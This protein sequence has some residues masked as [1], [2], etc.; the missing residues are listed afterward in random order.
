MARCRIGLAVLLGA[1]AGC[2]GEEPPLILP[3]AGLDAS[4]PATDSGAASDAGAPNDAGF[5]P[6]ADAATAAEDA[7]AAPHD[8]SQPGGPDTGAAGDDAAQPVSPDA[9]QPAG[10]DAALPAGPDAAAPAGLDAASPAGQD[11]AQAPGEDAA[12]PAGDDAGQPAGPDADTCAPQAFLAQQ[13]QLDIYLMLDTSASMTTSIGGTDTRWTAIKSALDSFLSAPSTGLS[14]GLQYFPIMDT[15]GC[16]STATSCS[17]DGECGSCGPCAASQ[18]AGTNTVFGGSCMSGDYASPAVEI[19]SL[20]GARSAIV[21]SMA[22][23]SPEGGTPTS[24][25]LVGLLDHAK[26]WASLFPDHAVIALLATDGEPTECITSQPYLMSVASAA[27]SGTP[28]IPT[29]VIG[30]GTSLPAVNSIAV[31]GGTGSAYMVS[32]GTGLAAEFLTVLDTVRGKSA[33]CK[34][35]IPSGASSDFG[36]VNVRFTPS[37]GPAV[38]FPNVGLCTAGVDGWFYDNASAPK[39]IV[40]CDYS[41]QAVKADASG[42]LDVLVGCPMVK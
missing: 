8:A 7:A 15:H 16:S 29:F 6:G 27:L 32:P 14:V 37:S 36:K 31:A 24:A 18:C 11:A 22:M 13:I 3:D 35:L 26:S 23:R 17:G 30:V 19:T 21:N 42:T 40:L 39:N 4:S 28:R 2:L 9:A 10:D 41:C 12:L 25:A 34:Y 33:D 1:L 5:V 20:P 38:S